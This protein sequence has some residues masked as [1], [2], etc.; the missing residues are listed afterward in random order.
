[1]IT[2]LK[3]YPILIASVVMMASFLFKILLVPDLKV[4]YFARDIVLF[5]IVYYVVKVLTNSLT[6]IL[7]NYWKIL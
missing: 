7:K 3:Y 2:S 4:T 6:R 5:F 1:M